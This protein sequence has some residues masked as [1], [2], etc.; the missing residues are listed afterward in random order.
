MQLTNV[1]KDKTAQKIYGKWLF[2]D[3]KYQITILITTEKVNLKNDKALLEIFNNN[4]EWSDDFLIF[5]DAGNK[6]YIK[7]ADE[8]NLFFG[9]FTFPRSLITKWEIKLNRVHN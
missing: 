2:E 3:N 1:Q 6:Y 5:T 4:C 7:Y 8:K 9:E